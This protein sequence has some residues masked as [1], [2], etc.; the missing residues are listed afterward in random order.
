MGRASLDS[1]Y[2]IRVYD[3]RSLRASNPERWFLLPM[4][5]THVAHG[6]HTAMESAEAGTVHSGHATA[7]IHGAFAMDHIGVFA[8]HHM[9]VVCMHGCVA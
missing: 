6:R 7:H 1:H 2:P 3:K 4:A 8:M 5:A 9:S